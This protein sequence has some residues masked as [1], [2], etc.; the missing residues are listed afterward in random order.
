MKRAV[1][2]VLGMVVVTL[3][4]GRLAEAAAPDDDPNV[5]RV[6]SPAVACR[7]VPQSLTAIGK[8]RHLNDTFDER[9]CRTGLAKQTLRID[10]DRSPWEVC[11]AREAEGLTYPHTFNAE[12][13][14]WFLPDLVAHHRAHC[15][16]AVYATWLILA[17]VAEAESHPEAP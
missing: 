4:G 3:L 15:G 8:M 2:L 11:A 7:S 12:P 10:D 17:V 14:D 5:P 16:N 13:A 6:A 1:V 9:A